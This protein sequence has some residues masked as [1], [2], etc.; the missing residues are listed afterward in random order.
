[1]STEKKESSYRTIRLA[2][3]WK[4]Q[5]YDYQERHKS[6]LTKI[7]L[8]SLL[9]TIG[10][11]YYTFLFVTDSNSCP[12]SWV[13]DSLYLVLVMHFTNIIQQVTV[14]TGCE[15]FLCSGICNLCLDIFEIAVLILMMDQVFAST[16]CYDVAETKDEY[17]CLLVNT[18]IYWIFF[19][20]SWF[21]KIHSFCQGPHK[22]ELEKELEEEEKLHNT[23]KIQ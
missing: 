12:D 16:H 7:Y 22:E 14:I 2:E 20:I 13:R 5:Q 9:V 4:A 17:V 23:N 6:V 10:L 15:A 11:A 19:A 3:K 18:I 21:I 1:M 8:V